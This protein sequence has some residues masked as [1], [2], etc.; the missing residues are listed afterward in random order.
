MGSCYRLEAHVQ[1]STET[2]LFSRASTT[3]GD[4]ANTNVNL[5]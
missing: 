1:L 3:F 4:E 2:K 5:G